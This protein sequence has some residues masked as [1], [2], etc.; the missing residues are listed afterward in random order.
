MTTGPTGRPARTVGVLAAAQVLGGVGVASGIA[1]NGLLAQE[2]SG[3]TSRSGLA[4]TMGVL[5]AALLAV[6]LSRLAAR[7][8]RR[9]ALATG[10]AVGAAGAVLSLA[11][12]RVGSF[13]LLLVGAALFGGGSAAGL[14]ARY[15][16]IDG[17]GEAHRARSLSLVVWAATVGSVVGPN[18]SGPGG[19]MGAALGVPDLAGPFLFSLAG[20]GLAALGL[21]AF[22]R[23]DPLPAAAVRAGRADGTRGPS[24]TRTALRAVRSSPGAVLGLTAL[25][26]AHA[27]MVAVMVMTPLHLHDGGATL[28]VVGIVISVH[29]AGM[30]ALSPVMGLVADRFGRRAGIGLG[31][32]V[33][34]V[35]CLVAAT[36]PP[37]AHTRLGVALTLLGLGWSAC[38]VAGSTLLS[39]SVP[40]DVRT[41]VQGLSDLVMGLVAASA[42]VFAGPVVERLGFGALGCVAAALLVP[43]VVLLTRPALRYEAV[44][45][46]G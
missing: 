12:A 25:G 26:I 3:S 18:L 45:G 19:R 13:G 32:V 36:S 21:W 1:V 38:V 37:M 6:P 39:E 9:P 29:I 15:A 40:P 33:L 11:A 41:S 22:L 28:E 4:Q 5:G 27:V 16:A 31:V 23:P 7:R 24:P 35:A 17:V 10:Y 14:Q 2:I 34:A 30:Y 43:V 8:G 44:G 46:A 20:Y 42:G